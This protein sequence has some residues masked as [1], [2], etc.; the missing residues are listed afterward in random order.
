MKGNQCF[1]ELICICMSDLAM[2]FLWHRRKQADL[3][4]SFWF[5]KILCFEFGGEG[6]QRKREEA[7]VD[8]YHDA[9]N[10]QEHKMLFSYNCIFAQGYCS[11]TTLNSIVSQLQ[12]FK[13][14]PLIL[15]HRTLILT[16][17][18]VPTILC[19]SSLIIKRSVIL[20]TGDIV[21]R[22]HIISL[23]DRIMVQ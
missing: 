8:L 16:H 18:T 21:S 14:L 3:L 23:L 1:S 20:Y 15:T 2:P 5:W 7:I 19:A 9:S 6:L 17:R 10:S 12:S 11:Y 4:P 13:E 22:L